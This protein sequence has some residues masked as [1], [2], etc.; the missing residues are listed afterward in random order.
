MRFAFASTDSTISAYAYGSVS[1]IGDYGALGD[2]P[3]A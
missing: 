3:E 2:N 1:A